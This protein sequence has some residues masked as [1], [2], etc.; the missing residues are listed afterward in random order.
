[1][2]FIDYL[3]QTAIKNN[4][5]LCAGFDPMIESLPQVFIDAGTKAATNED[6][7]HETL[8]GF[9]RFTIEALAAEVACV[10]PNIAFFE[11]Y[12]IGGLRAL[13]DLLACATEHRV[14]TILDCKRG[15]IG[16]TAESYAHAYFGKKKNGVT[17]PPPFGAD[18]I[19]VNPFLGFDTVKVFLDSAAEYDKGIFV[20]VK[21][22]NPG[23]DDLQ[24]LSVDGS[25]ISST[26]AKWIEKNSAAFMGTSQAAK[27]LSGLGAVVGAT[28][29]QHL[30]ALR[31][32]MPSALLLVPGYGAQ[33]GTAAELSAAFTNTNLGAVV[34]A[35]RGLMS[36]FTDKSASKEMLRSE[37]IAT[38]KSLSAPLT[39]AK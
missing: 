20:L 23:S 28:H 25:S 38:A 19:T 17:T 8:S 27:N 35:S 12:G 11:Q 6:A 32:E 9:Y 39:N 5:S 7:I 30:L 2:K 15:D 14:P 16:S 34:N 37:L 24:D 26:V 4:S 1:M 36:T 29:P 31:N 3:C 21:T 10:K 33:G 22:S 13:Q 18:S